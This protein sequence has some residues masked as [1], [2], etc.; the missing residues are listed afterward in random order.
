MKRVSLT[1]P[2]TLWTRAALLAAAVP[3]RAGTLK[4]PGRWM[5][6][7]AALLLAPHLTQAAD[8]CTSFGLVG[9]NFKVPS[10]GKCKPFMGFFPG[11]PFVWTGGACASSDGTSV[12]FSIQAVDGFGIHSLRFGVSPSG[13]AGFGTECVADTNPGV[14]GLSDGF[15][16]GFLMTAMPCATVP[17][18]AG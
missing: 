18:P 14:G 7:A 12:N 3:A 10:K 5:A 17:V 13:S 2:R 15:C 6:L 16:H 8:Y 4:G 9:K 1:S 11:Q